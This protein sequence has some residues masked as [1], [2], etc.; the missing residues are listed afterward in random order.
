M[1]KRMELSSK[2]S[3]IRKKL[4][5]DDT[6]PVDI[7]NLAQTIDGL[8]LVFSPLGKNISGVCY[9][10][11]NSKLIVINSDMSIGRQRFSLAHELYHLFFDDLSTNTI[12]LLSIGNGDE[13]EK[14]AD[15]FASFFLIP[16]ASLYAFIE[17]IKDEKGRSDLSVEDVIRLE[18]YYGVS[19]KAMLFRLQEEEILSPDQVKSMD[20]G[21]IELA[22][23]L[24]YDTSI[25]RPAT[26]KNKRKVLGHYIS[27]AEKRLKEGGISQGKY[28]EILLDAFRYDIVYGLDE[29]GDMPLD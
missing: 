17:D 16:Q 21:V 29:E 8:S 26:E 13:N 9:K 27:L 28:E 7:F 4:G 22:A 2:A 20:G 25:Y 23:R 1:S 12:S 14:K 3:Y 15:Q 6:S 18:Q 5:V 24:G 11:P 19:H 10:I